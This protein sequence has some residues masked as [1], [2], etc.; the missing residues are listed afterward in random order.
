[1][2]PYAAPGLNQYEDEIMEHVM[3]YFDTEADII[4]AKYRGQKYVMQRR[5]AAVLIS[6]ATGDLR[7]A[8]RVVHRNRTMIYHYLTTT[9][10]MLMY[11]HERERIH[12]LCRRIGIDYHKLVDYLNFEEWRQWQN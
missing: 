5:T 11:G 6:F 4:T 3:A 1:M 9:R 2:N 7:R 12:T 8:V 10:D